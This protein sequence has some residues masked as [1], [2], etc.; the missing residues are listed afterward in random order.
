M[1]FN[2][3]AKIVMTR[4]NCETDNVPLIN[5]YILL[6]QKRFLSVHQTE[7]IEGKEC[8]WVPLT[9][10]TAKNPGTSKALNTHWLSCEQSTMTFEIPD[11]T[12]H[13]WILI[14]NKASGQ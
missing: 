4:P 7:K 12:P 8:W 10:S 2:S 11:A 9:F 6:F 5:I 14:N 3:F 1:A 13:D